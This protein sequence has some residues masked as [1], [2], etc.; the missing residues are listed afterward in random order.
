[1]LFSSLI[2]QLPRTNLVESQPNTYIYLRYVAPAI[3][4]GL[5]FVSRYSTV[6]YA[7]RSRHDHELSRKIYKYVTGNLQI[8]KYK[9]WRRHHLYN[10]RHIGFKHIKLI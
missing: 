9:F 4:K 5:T 7:N 3:L 6:W 8:D 2:A 1:M 10:L